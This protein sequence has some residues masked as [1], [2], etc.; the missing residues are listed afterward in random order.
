MNIGQY[1]RSFDFKGYGV[2]FVDRR[3]VSDESKVILTPQVDSQ[4]NFSIPFYKEHEDMIRVM[5]NDVEQVRDIDYE[6]EFIPVSLL[7]WISTDFDLDTT[8]KIVVEVLV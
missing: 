6:L 4:I 5:V 3:I 7:K 1:L 8:D 2:V